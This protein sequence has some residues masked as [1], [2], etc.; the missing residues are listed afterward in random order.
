MAL[1][2]RASFV[3]QAQSFIHQKSALRMQNSKQSKHGTG[4]IPLRIAVNGYIGKVG[5]EITTKGLMTQP[6]KTADISIQQCDGVRE[7]SEILP[8]IN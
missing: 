7:T 4:E 5:L 3:V 1:E 8:Q 6:V 2:Y